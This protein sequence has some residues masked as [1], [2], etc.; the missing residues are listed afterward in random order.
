LQ[1]VPVL[2][3][4]LLMAGCGDGGG[5]AGESAEVS[6]LPVST[7]AIMDSLIN[8]SADPLFSEAWGSPQ[9]EEEWLEIEQLARQLQL[10][11]ELLPVPGTGPMDGEWTA[12]AAF[13]QYASQLSAA[14]GRALA[15]AQRRR[16]QELVQ[17]GREISAVCNA[18][19][20]RFAPGLP[21]VNLTN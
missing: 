3:A 14:A 19:H 17:I 1:I 8:H 4:A 2:A 9:N 11:G 5:Q 13:S 16:E 18:C 10:G 6:R 20:Q 12:D 15:A 21:T 7:S